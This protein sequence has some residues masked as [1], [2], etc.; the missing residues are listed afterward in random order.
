MKPVRK[1][2]LFVVRLALLC[3]VMLSFAFSPAVSSL[4]ALPDDDEY[5][6]AEDT[7][8][9]YGYIATAD[10]LTKQILAHVVLSLSP[11]SVS[12]VPADTVWKLETNEAG[13]AFFSLPVKISSADAISLFPVLNARVFPHSGSGFNFISPVIVHAKI[14]VFNANGL[15]VTVE[16][17]TG[18]HAFVNLRNQ[19]NGLY[20]YRVVGDKGVVSSGKFIKTNG[21]VKNVRGE[22][23]DNAFKSADFGFKSTASEVAYYWLKWRKE[24]YKTDSVRLSLHEG[25]NGTQTIAMEPLPLDTLWATGNF[26]AVD[27]NNMGLEDV[28]LYFKPDSVFNHTPDTTFK[29]ETKADGSISF[30]VPVWIS[31]ISKQDPIN[32]KYQLKWSEDGYKTDSAAFTLTEGDNGTQTIKLTPLPVDTTWGQVFIGIRNKETGESITDITEL[33]ITPDSI[34]DKTPDTTYHIKT[35]ESG[36]IYD[37]FPVR[38]SNKLPPSEIRAKYKIKWVK[39]GFF[40]DSTEVTLKDG[41]NDPVFVYLQPLPPGKVTLIDT[42]RDLETKKPLEN[43]ITNIIVADTVFATDTTDE[44][45]VFTFKNIPQGTAL[46]LNIHGSTSHYSLLSV[47]GYKTPSDVPLNTTD[48]IFGV[49][50]AY[51]IARNPI[52]SATHIRQFCGENTNQDTIPFSFDNDTNL[53]TYV[54]ESDREQYRAWFKQFEKDTDSAFIFKESETSVKGKEGI[55]IYNGSYATDAYQGEYSTPLGKV[56]PVIY[57][58]SSQFISEYSVFVHE[59]LRGLG[60]REVGR[61][62]SVMNTNASVFTDEDKT[63]IKIGR[64]YYKQFYDGKTNIDLDFISDDE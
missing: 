2:L 57:A 47:S 25:D 60:Y 35:N 28:I 24:G 41:K 36:F 32:A 44:N 50:N 62:N 6:N 45:G 13:T 38:I 39:D 64:E 20:V 42:V 9:G 23:P 7:V 21:V 63:L 40:T 26:K 54:T 19:S 48:T 49:Y 33:E 3:S 34:A 15:L 46:T 61:T 29:M 12:G 11:D 51:L 56:Y 1:L 10:E 4:S 8:T 55:F 59:D 58:I 52:T 43:I 31:N 22:V 53:S 37:N 14:L 27:E 17:I 18:R 5:A 30:K 16:E